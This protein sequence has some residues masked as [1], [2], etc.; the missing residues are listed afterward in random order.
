MPAF[1]SLS[2]LKTDERPA[3]SPLCTHRPTPTECQATK[4]ISPPFSLQCCLSAHGLALLQLFVPHS[5]QSLKSPSS[6]KPINSPFRWIWINIIFVNFK[7]CLWHVLKV[8]LALC[9]HKFFLL[10][11]IFLFLFCDARHQI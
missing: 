2:G 5:T 11:F 7:L 3:L 1:Y 9:F 6:Q 4:H 10:Y 8:I